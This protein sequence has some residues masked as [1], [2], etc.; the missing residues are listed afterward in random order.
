VLGQDRS[1][2]SADLD[3][4][5]VRGLDAGGMVLYPAPDTPNRRLAYLA[6]DLFAD[7]APDVSDARDGSVT[8][9]VRP[10]RHW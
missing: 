5:G 1:L 6:G 3:A 7:L 8:P 10:D 9:Y 2:S 4:H